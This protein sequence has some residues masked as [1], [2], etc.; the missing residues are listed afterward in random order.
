VISPDDPGVSWLGKDDQEF[1]L[2]AE[3]VGIAA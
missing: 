1:V 2:E 3:V